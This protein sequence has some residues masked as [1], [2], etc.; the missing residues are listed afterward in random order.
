MLTAC[1][2]NGDEPSDSADAASVN[3]WIHSS[4]KKSY[5]WLDEIGS[6]ES[7]KTSADP[8]TFFDALISDNERKTKGSS[9]YYYSYI[10]QKHTKTRVTDY[11]EDT[12]GIEYVLY[13]IG[14]NTS[15]YFA[16]VLYVVPDSPAEKA[17]V[18]RGQ[19]IKTID[20]SLV[21]AANYAK[22]NSGSGVKLGVWEGTITSDNSV[23]QTITV[24]AQASMYVSPFLKDTVFTAANGAKVGYLM[25]TKFATG[26]TG[27]DDKAWDTRMNEIIAAQKV[28]GVTEYILDLRYNSGGYLDC[29][30]RLAS[31]LA[32]QSVLSKTFCTLSYNSKSIYKN[33]SYSFSS[34]YAGT[35]NLNLARVYILAGQRTASASEAVINGLAPMM[36]VI[37]VGETTEGKNLGSVSIESDSYDWVMH[38]IVARIVNAEGFGDYANGLAPTEGY[39]YEEFQDRTP[40]APIGSPNDYMISLVLKDIAGTTK[41]PADVAHHAPDASLKPGIAS[42]DRYAA[43]AVKL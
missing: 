27:F 36:K 1:S 19:W 16:R 23:S 28:A 2:N 35:A 18:C 43:P 9:T 33:K 17:G 10:E 34:D 30:I 25:Y 5:L 41:A 15:S 24:E 29:A 32:P 20:G 37:H 12:Y 38:P 7:Y 22:L 31:L 8:E 11:P 26:P 6:Y 42:I 4:M 14:S 40:F 3:E 13:T 39:V 21:T